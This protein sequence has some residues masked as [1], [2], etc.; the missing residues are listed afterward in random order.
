MKCLAGIALLCLWASPALAQGASLDD[1]GVE[2]LTAVPRELRAGDDVTVSG[3]GCAPGNQVRFE[4]R[5]P[6]PHS[7]A[8]GAVAGD[9]TFVQSIRI[10]S[11]TNVGRSWLRATCLTADSEQRVM[12]A[13]LLIRRPEFVITW[14]NVLFGAGAALVT[15][16]IGL[17]VLR[18]SH[19]RHPRSS[20]RGAGRRGR[21]RKRHRS[22]ESRS[23]SAARTTVDG[24]AADPQ[25]GPQFNGSRESVNKELEVD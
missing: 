21:G 17:S 11:T 16:G 22:T 5:D 2:Q 4:L 9:G 1:S 23:H 25:N 8:D 19:H 13:V 3:S 20:G 6:A 14:T 12:E 15:A 24:N 10:P 7:S 18:G